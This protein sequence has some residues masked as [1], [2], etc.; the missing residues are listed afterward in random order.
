MIPFVDLKA[1]YT[2]IKDE[3]NAAIQ[4]VLDTC[5]FTLGSEVAAFEEEFASYSQAQYGIGVNTGTS[6]LHLALLAAGIG[7]G[8]EVITVPFTFVATVAAI[9]YTGAT[10]VFVDI[11]PRTFTIDVK[12]IEAAITDKTKAILP[13]H[14]YG[15][16]ADMDPILDI[17]KRHGLV[18]IEDAAQAH[19][20]E[21]KGK[22][23]GS[24][25]DMGCF[26]F[27]P[28]K[29]LGAYGEGGMVVTSNPEYTRTMRMLRD[30]G[31]EQKYQHVLKGYNFRLEGIQGAVLR[32]KL[33]H[34]EAWTEARRAAA[35]H[36]NELMSD[37][38][39]A[40]PEAMPYARHVYHIYAI[41][42]QQRSEWQQA[43]QDKGIQTGIHYPIPVHLLPAY[44]DL[45]Y[46]QG[47]FPHSEQAANEVLSLPMFAE[48]SP[49]QCKEV[50]KAVI[51]LANQSLAEP[52]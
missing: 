30:W 5:Q 48:L 31:A 24:I 3:V 27:Y 20:A 41:R 22:R 39:V 35:A 29:N 17:A 44:A 38:G 4:G 8:D 2:G 10:P 13:V 34:L 19:G 45:G 18:V 51:L 47:D 21:Y 43:L 42:T 1:Q 6:A 32:V 26:S 50:S 33:R 25:G 16:P 40:T 14:L 49:A 12:A 37:S 11:D 9:Y 52:A 36:Y 28:G 46:T 23:V 7:P 15:Q